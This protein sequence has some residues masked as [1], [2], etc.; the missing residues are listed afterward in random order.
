MCGCFNNGCN[1]GC[2]GN[3]GNGGGRIFIIER[4]PRGPRGYTG[5]TGATGPQGPQGPV[6]ATGPQ[7]PAGGGLASY[8][9]GYS[10][11]TTTQALTS[12]AT[13][14]TLGTFMPSSNVTYGTNSITVTNGG[15]YEINYGISGS[16]ETT[17]DLTLSVGRNGTAIPAGVRSKTFTAGQTDLLMGSFIVTLSAGDVLT[18]LLASA[19]DITFTPGANVNSYLTVKQLNG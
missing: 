2:G 12:T 4:G 19:Q 1:N 3:G 6:G 10:A 17:S 9:G 5:A 8:G 15:D 18:L 16:V 7:G 13:T 14:L 11:A